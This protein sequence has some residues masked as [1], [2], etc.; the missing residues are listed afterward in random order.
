MAASKQEVSVKR[1]HLCQC[2]KAAIQSLGKTLEAYNFTEN[3]LAYLILQ[4]FQKITKFKS[5]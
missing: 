5:V 2:L 1:V 4:F 3:E